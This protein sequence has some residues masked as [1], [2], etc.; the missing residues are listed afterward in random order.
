VAKRCSGLPPISINT[1]A[2][3]RGY[4]GPS[5][6]T[7]ACRSG[8]SGL[9]EFQHQGLQEPSAAT[10]ASLPLFQLLHRLGLMHL[11]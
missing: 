2:Q 9:A 11:Q 7:R 8:A 6:R 5:T 3:P 10:A 1:L 4:C